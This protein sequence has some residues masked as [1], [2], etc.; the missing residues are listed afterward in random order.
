MAAPRICPRCGTEVQDETLDGLCPQCLVHEGLA[1]EES[2][3]QWEGLADGT[4]VSPHSPG[5]TRFGDYE[6]LEVIAHGKPLPSRR[7]A[8]YLRTIAESIHHAH[9]HG[10]LHRMQMQTWPGHSAR[11]N[12]LAMAGA[13]SQQSNE[14]GPG[15]RPGVLA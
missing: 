15:L 2:S 6:L 4:G 12:R 9:E 11:V 10:I 5:I 8:T 14:R 7:A 1:P 13:R 3:E